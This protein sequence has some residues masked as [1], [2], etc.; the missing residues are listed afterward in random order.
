MTTT[1]TAASTLAAQAASLDTAHRSGQ[2][3]TTAELEAVH[4]ADHA[5]AA[6]AAELGRTYYATLTARRHGPE[7]ATTHQAVN[8][9]RPVTR[10]RVAADRGWTSLEA[11]G[12]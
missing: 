8:G 12:W 3:W 6:L 7:A 4:A 2:H 5:L 9:L 11:M 10:P 1:R